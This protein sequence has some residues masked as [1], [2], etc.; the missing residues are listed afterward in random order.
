MKHSEYTN[1]LELLGGKENHKVSSVFDDL[2]KNE[3]N[4]QVKKEKLKN[5]KKKVMNSL[6]A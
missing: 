6:K 2:I 1:A 5:W 4:S 3:S